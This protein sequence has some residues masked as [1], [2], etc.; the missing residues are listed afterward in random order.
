MTNHSCRIKFSSSPI[1]KSWPAFNTH[2]QASEITNVFAQWQASEFT[3]VLS[4]WKDYR[5]NRSYQ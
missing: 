3:N 2:W 4:H 5:M 1:Y